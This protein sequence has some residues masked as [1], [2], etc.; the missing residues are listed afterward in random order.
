MLERKCEPAEWQG[1]RW[2]LTDHICRGCL[3][4]ILECETGLFMCSSCEAETSGAPDAICGC[5]IKI[6]NS[7]RDGGFKCAPNLNRTPENPGAIVVT[8]AGNPEPMPA[9]VEGSAPA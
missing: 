3:G 7:K 2:N 6:S 4:R 8:F 9:V 1:R 5:G